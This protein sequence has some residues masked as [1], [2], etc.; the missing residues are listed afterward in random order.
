[1]YKV[2]WIKKQKIVCL[3]AGVGFILLILLCDSYA[4]MGRNSAA[5]YW[6]SD[7]REGVS[8]MLWLEVFFGIMSALMF[9]ASIF[10]F[11]L[12]KNGKVCSECKLVYPKST[13]TC[14]KCKKNITYAKSITEYRAMP[15]VTGMPTMNTGVSYPPVQNNI[16]NI[17]YPPIQNNIPNVS[18][19]KFCTSCGLKMKGTDNFCPRCGKKN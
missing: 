17:S 2:D 3:F 14:F 9:S 4:N 18:R 13:T 7:V 5:Y 15:P 8:G 19:E 11:Y 10:M 6:S 12:D 1:M 16:P